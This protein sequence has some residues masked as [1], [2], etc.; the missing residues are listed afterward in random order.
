MLHSNTSPYLALLNIACIA[1][2]WGEALSRFCRKGLIP[3]S[4]EYGAGATSNLLILSG[5]TLGALD[6]RRRYAVVGINEY[7]RTRS[8]YC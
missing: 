7:R 8:N 4:G 1:G 2:R 5:L 6:G 3:N